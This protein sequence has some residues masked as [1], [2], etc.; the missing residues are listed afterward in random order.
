MGQQ[1]TVEFAT[2]HPRNNPRRGRT[3]LERVQHF[4]DSRDAAGA[5]TSFT[6]TSND[7]DVE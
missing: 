5:V 1:V 4:S 3:V 2:G 6:A 7:F